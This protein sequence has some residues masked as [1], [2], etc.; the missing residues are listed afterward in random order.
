MTKQFP[1]HGLLPKDATQASSFLK[2]YPQYDGDNVVIAILD[3]G[4]YSL[5]LPLPL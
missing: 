2:K 1:V 3:T 4:T 5:S